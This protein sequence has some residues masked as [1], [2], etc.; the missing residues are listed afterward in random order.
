MACVL[1]L[2]GCLAGGKEPEPGAPYDGVGLYPGKQQSTVLNGEIKFKNHQGESILLEAR[3]SVPC[4][5]GRCAVI[6]NPAV[7]TLS[8]PGPGPFSMTLNQAAKD[9]MLIATCQKPSGENRVAHTW[10]LEE[11]PVLSGIKLSF[12]RPYPPLR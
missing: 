1:L 3:H 6:G 4:E 11:D 7:A 8:L 12:D 9:L 2:G 5:H 10:L